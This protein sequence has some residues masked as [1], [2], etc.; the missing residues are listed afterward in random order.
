[1]DQR[2]V[3]VRGLVRVPKRA[4]GQH[5][6]GDHGQFDLSKHLWAWP[7]LFFPQLKSVEK[8][9]RQLVNGGRVGGQ[10]DGGQFCFEVRR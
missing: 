3:G 2:S 5:V 9:L 8:A 7:K 4:A 6:E 10:F 1:M